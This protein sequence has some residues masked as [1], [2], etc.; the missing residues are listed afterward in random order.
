MIDRCDTDDALLIDFPPSA[1]LLDAVDAVTEMAMRLRHAEGMANV[2]LTAID[3]GELWDEHLKHA[4]G[5][6]SSYLTALRQGMA[7]WRATIVHDPDD[8]ATDV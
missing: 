3:Q 1:Q 8:P 6:L 4:L 2:C 5:L 7:R